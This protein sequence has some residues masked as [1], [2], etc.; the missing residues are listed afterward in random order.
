MI[1]ASTVAW[2]RE[3]EGVP[4]QLEVLFPGGWGRFEFLGQI[5]STNRRLLA[6]PDLRPDRYHVCVAR[7]QTA[8]HGRRGRAWASVADASLTFSLARALRMGE[9]PDPSL[10]L[11]IGVGL[12]CGLSRCGLEGF[13]LKW[14]NDLVTRDGAKLAGV[15]VEARGKQGEYPAAL[16]VG[17]GLNCSGADGLRVDR[18]IADLSD[19]SGPSD[20]ALGKLFQA[21]VVEVVRAWNA[22]DQAGLSGCIDDLARIDYLRGRDVV[23]ID[24]GDQGRVAG[25]DPSDGALLLAQGEKIKRLYSG[26][27]SVRVLGRG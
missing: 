4:D 2:Q 7:E 12:A 22:F 23:V 26:E 1:D 18:P 25:I 14:P 11:A 20:L 13:F 24:T 9:V 27:I 3:L 21:I 8:G 17:I 6:A 15:L 16:V 5:D 19:L 10:S